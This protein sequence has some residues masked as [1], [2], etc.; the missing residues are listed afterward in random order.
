LDGHPEDQIEESESV[1]PVHELKHCGKIGH[2]MR[3]ELLVGQDVDVLETEV[4][5]L[6]QSVT[7]KPFVESR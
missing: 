1:F 6:A 3:D 2:E 7:R 5:N 4:Y